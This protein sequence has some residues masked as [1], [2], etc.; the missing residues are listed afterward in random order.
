MTEKTDKRA[1]NEFLKEESHFLR[2]TIADGLAHVETG[3][4]SDDDTQLIKFH[5]SYMQDDRD[6]RGERSKKK[7]EKAFS[8]MI[9]LRLPG[10]LVSPEQ[11]I[12]LDDIA[13]TYANG[14]LRLTTR[15]TFQYHGVIKSNLR[16]TMQAI[17]GACL[18]TIAACGDVNRNVMCVANPFFSPVHA[19]AGEF[20]RKVSDHLLPKT[21][22]YH[23]IWL[24]GD[25]VEDMSRPA[26]VDT[27]PLY[28]THYLPRKFKIVIA[29]PPHND[30]DVFAH[31][32]GFIAITN[33]KG[34]LEGWNV[35]I[36]G[37]MGMT[38]GDTATFPRAGDVIGFCTPEQAI[39]VAEKV[40]LVQRDWGNRE[41]RANARLKYTVERFG[42]DKYRTEVESRLGYKL[43]EAR[44]F[45]FT[46]MG[47][48][49]GWY[50]GPD[51][52]WHL[53]LF[54][55]AGRIRD[56]PGRHLRTAIREIA[57][58][59]GITFSVTGN[60]NIIICNASAK[61]KT[62]IDA[63]LKSHG[64]DISTSS[65]L[66]RN[67]I[68]CVALP[69]CA[70]A[71]AESERFLP[72]LITT[73]EDSLDKAGLRN[74]D[75]VIRMTGCPNGCGRP[76]MAEIGF[77]GRSPGLYNLY[78]GAAHEGTRLNKL[79]AQDV[80]KARIVELLEPLFLRYAKERDEGERFG[81]FVIRAGVVKPTLGGNT[82]HDDI[83]L[84]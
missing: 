4:I 38:H 77:V 70:L 78:L 21:S 26:V 72:E 53:G 1:R 39:D 46:S 79:Y 55:E 29:V 13:G 35:S 17:N 22:A 60:Q 59:G 20:A 81:D 61:Q 19:A 63:I 69:T 24:E 2:G 73:L 27:E 62:K 23:E 25:K 54:I 6:I 45:K 52:K 57:E 68:S 65:G 56:F 40:M 51:K 36:G 67:S 5:G 64:I 9:R 15:A 37:G 83:T 31:D 58:A 42:V 47:D 11:W 30:G 18:D 8:F 66:R 41:N 32:L 43:G 3:A 49:I 10:G 75:I 12:K 80:G 33:A 7:L 50:Q 84:A 44:P 74:D 16:R 28:G 76:Y 82:F 34:E 71:L 48:P 14:S